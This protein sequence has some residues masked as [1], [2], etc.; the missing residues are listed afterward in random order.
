ME[1][2]LGGIDVSRRQHHVGFTNADATQRWG[3]LTVPND[4]AGAQSLATALTEQARVH[5]C[6]AVR[7]GLEATGV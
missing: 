1:P 2:L 6:D 4:A 3:R 5:A 7:I